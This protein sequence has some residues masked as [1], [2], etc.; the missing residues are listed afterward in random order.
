M[1]GH[2]EHRWLSRDISADLGCLFNKEAHNYYK[3]MH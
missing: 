1:L 2:V 3:D